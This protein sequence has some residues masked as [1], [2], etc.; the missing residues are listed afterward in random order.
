MKVWYW[1]AVST[2][3]LAGCSGEEGADTT[4]RERDG[5]RPLVY[6]SNYPL[7]YFAERISAPLVE[8]RLAAPAGE[9]P[10]FWKPAPEDVQALQ[11][12]DLVVLNGA[13][14]ETWLN[15]VSLPTA[16]LVDTS[17]GFR[18]RFIVQEM[19]THSHGPQGKHEHTATAFTTWL[20][21]TLAVEQARVIRDAFSVRWPDHRG[22]FEAR[23]DELAEELDALDRG[24]EEIVEAA[25]D[26][27]VVFSHPVYQY[28]ARRYGVNGRSVHWEPHE[29]PA[30]AM[31]Q[32]LS[33]LLE[34]HP[35]R[36]MIWEAE[37]ASDIAAKLAG[38]GIRSVVFD[39][40]AGPP[41]DGDFASVM[42]HNTEALG[43][44]Y[45]QP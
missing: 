24:I 18:D 13:S 2:I 41:G 33:T 7:Q 20:D 6:A 26:E 10:A 19:T 27:P 16:R 45:G 29:M 15:Q 21:L 5:G 31:W 44:L 36:W 37:P 22:R 17:A 42:E 30:E 38:L 8:V 4:S 34:S 9:D 43:V 32:E 39:P 3:L 12:A 1:L 25:A 35:A 14:Y 28:F 11:Q 40:C 23:F